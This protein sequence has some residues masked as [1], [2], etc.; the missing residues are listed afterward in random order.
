VIRASKPRPSPDP[1]LTWVFAMQAPHHPLA[2]PKPTNLLSPISSPCGSLYR[3][4]KAPIRGPD[5]RQARAAP[6]RPIPIRDGYHKA[7]RPF[8]DIFCWQKDRNA[9]WHSPSAKKGEI[10]A[11]KIHSSQPNI[12]A[13]LRA[14]P[15][16]ARKRRQ[17]PVVEPLASLGN[18][19]LRALGQGSSP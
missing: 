2:L 14:D 3:S 4:E 7:G 12:A 10:G 8:D 9:G 16:S 17:K 6:G 13:M 19:N 5:R 11:M 1:T 15:V 18:A